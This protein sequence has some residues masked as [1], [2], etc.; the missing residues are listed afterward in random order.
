MK[1]ILR[2][3]TS[4]ILYAGLIVSI[5]LSVW[6]LLRTDIYR[7]QSELIL[8]QASEIQWRASQS[9]EKVARI[10]GYLNVAVRSGEKPP[11][12]LLEIQLLSFNLKSLVHLDYAATFIT[13]Q[14]IA[15]LHKAIEAVDTVVLPVAAIGKHCEQAL[16]PM[17]VIDEYLAGLASAAVDHSQALS[18]TSHIATD[19]A[20]NRLVF[21]GALSALIL[22]IISIHQYSRIN[23][24][25][26]QH[27]RSFSLLFAHMT[28]TRIT[29]LRL[30]LGYLDG[31]S[32]PPPEMADAALRTI[33]EL[34]FDQ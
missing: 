5:C 32:H 29:A 17:L 20:R 21:F 16:G 6:S 1:S 14:N 9:K 24:K 23:R 3:S 13:P 30:F 15:G 34:E 12:L 25:K 11:R 33:V 18:A 8:G 31:K 19:A 27:I 10:I 22:S 26:D 2:H 7:Q 28:R 4:L